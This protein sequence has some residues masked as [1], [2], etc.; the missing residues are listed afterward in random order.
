MCVH[1]CVPPSS[2]TPHALSGV[3]LFCSGLHGLS[4][5]FPRGSFPFLNLSLRVWAGLTAPHP[6]WALEVTT[7]PGPLLGPWEQI[8]LAGLPPGRWQACSCLLA[9]ALP[10]QGMACLRVGPA[11]KMAELETRLAQR[12]AETPGN[13]YS[14]LFYDT[15][16]LFGSSQFEPGSYN[17]QMKGCE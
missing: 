8:P 2:W 16:S 12:P 10:W 3:A 6:S 1:A 4:D 14:S 17:L 15:T 11:P 7:R 9:A 13:P 5:S